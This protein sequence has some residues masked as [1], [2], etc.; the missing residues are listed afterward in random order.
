[1]RG[2]ARIPRLTPEDERELGRR[3]QANNDQDALRQ[4]VEGN[5]RF[6][7]SYAKRYRGL[8]VPFLDLIHEG[9][10]GLIEAAKR[11]DPD[12]NVKFITYAVWWIRQ[13][14]AH[15]LSLQSR[16]FALPQKLSGIA[17][18]IGREVA[19]LSE[20]LDRMPTP[21]KS[22]KTSRS[23]R[24]MSTRC[25]ESAAG[26]SLNER[27]WTR[28]GESDGPELV[29]VLEL[30]GIVPIE[31]ICCNARSPIASV[32]RWTSSTSRSATSSNCASGSI[33]TV[34]HV[35]CRRWAS[36]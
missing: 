25:C 8:G 13:A 15:A 1:L 27:V 34:S 30:A 7:V 22:R 31:T 33:A 29:E 35:R 36:S 19:A 12:R 17:A 6:V 24:R 11:F 3:I 10:L 4:L 18:R 2:I 5:L 21:A 32:M 26:T 20:E 14:I 28:A 23:L 16:A 9:N